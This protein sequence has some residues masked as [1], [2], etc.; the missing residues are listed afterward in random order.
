MGEISSAMQVTPSFMNTGQ[1]VPI[2]MESTNETGTVHWK[3][4]GKG[5]K[6]LKT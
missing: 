6:F 4:S 2:I 5:I 1:F 3:A